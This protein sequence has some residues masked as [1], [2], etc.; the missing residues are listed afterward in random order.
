MLCCVP[1]MYVWRVLE[2]E[3]PAQCKPGGRP[4]IMAGRVKLHCAERL[5]AGK[6]MVEQGMLVHGKAGH[7][8]HGM[9]GHIDAW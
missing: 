6:G 3:L 8:R 1:V 9:A 4:G 7:T 2:Q 5:R